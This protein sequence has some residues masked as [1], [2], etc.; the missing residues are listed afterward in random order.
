MAAN[1]RPIIM[2]VRRVARLLMRQRRRSG[3]RY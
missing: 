3:P 2:I 1:I